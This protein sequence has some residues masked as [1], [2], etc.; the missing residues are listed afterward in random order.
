MMAL[1][2]RKINVI[3][4]GLRIL[5]GKISLRLGTGSMTK[6]SLWK[7]IMIIMSLGSANLLPVTKNRE[8]S[9]QEELKNLCLKL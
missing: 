8:G 6:F 5:T 3:V 9:I 4:V 2:N 7:R 1:L